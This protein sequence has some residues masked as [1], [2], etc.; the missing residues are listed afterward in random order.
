MNSL[1]PEQPAPAESCDALLQ[2][3]NDHS[4]VGRREKEGVEGDERENILTA[5]YENDGPSSKIDAMIAVITGWYAR[6]WL[7]DG[8]FFV[9]IGG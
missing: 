9:G 4:L 6:R 3:M 5:R 7:N 2:S 1:L 8:L